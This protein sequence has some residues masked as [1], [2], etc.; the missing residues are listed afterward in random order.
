MDTTTDSPFEKWIRRLDPDIVVLN[1]EVYSGCYAKPAPTCKHCVSKSIKCGIQIAYVCLEDVMIYKYN[2]TK[3]K[4]TL[5]SSEYTKFSVKNIQVMY[6]ENLEILSQAI[7]IERWTTNRMNYLKINTRCRSKDGATLAEDSDF[8]Q[9]PSLVELIV[10]IVYP[11]T[12]LQELYVE[13]AASP[14]ERRLRAVE[15]VLNSKDDSEDSES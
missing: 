12:G 14:E 7:G 11:R 5:F 2:T 1:D 3:N 10:S 13:K 6:P 4:L 9:R 8:N 15:V